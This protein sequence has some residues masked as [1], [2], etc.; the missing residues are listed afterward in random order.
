MKVRELIALLETHDPEAEVRRFEPTHNY[1]RHKLA[2]PIR[3]VEEA[4]GEYDEYNREV[5]LA[6]EE[7]WDDEKP[8]FVLID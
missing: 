1:W 3:Q 5:V 2:R 4:S 8:M 7:D 6:D